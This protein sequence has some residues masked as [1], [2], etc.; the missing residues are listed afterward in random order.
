[1]GIPE[2]LDYWESLQSRFYSGTANK[3]EIKIYKL[4]SKTLR[5]ISKD[6]RYPSL[7]THEISEL[8]ARYGVKV[9]Q[10]YCEN[11]NPRAMRVFWVYGPLK[12]CITIIGLEPHPNDAKSNA[13]SKIRLSKMG[14]PIT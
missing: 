11:R 1:M 3:D 9:F 8:S 4:L 12:E 7:H 6:P 14:D 5:L 13:Y 2:M 10:S